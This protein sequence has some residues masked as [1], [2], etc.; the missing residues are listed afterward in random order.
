MSM[1]L[2]ASSHTI[3]SFSTSNYFFKKTLYTK[4]IIVYIVHVNL[5]SIR[6]DVCTAFHCAC[7]ISFLLFH[8]QWKSSSKSDL[9]TVVQKVENE[10]KNQKTFFVMV[11]RTTENAF[12]FCHKYSNGIWNYNL[13]NLDVQI[14]SSW[15]IL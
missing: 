10:N 4:E 14:S 7:N 8:Q 12:G 13:R 9:Q 1:F 11:L 6:T 2:Q 3:N 15:A 5:S